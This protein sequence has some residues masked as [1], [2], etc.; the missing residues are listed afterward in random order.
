MKE[1]NL[2]MKVQSQRRREEGQRYRESQWNWSLAPVAL[3]IPPTHAGSWANKFTLLPNYFKLTFYHL[4]PEESCPDQYISQNRCT[5][6]VTGSREVGQ[7]LIQHEIMF[8]EREVSGP[9][10]NIFVGTEHV[11]GGRGRTRGN[12]FTNRRQI[13]KHMATVHANREQQR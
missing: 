11:C 1:E 7:E 5:I 3:V 6:K 9:G 2:Q 10:Q 12:N 8:R 13:T 4:Q